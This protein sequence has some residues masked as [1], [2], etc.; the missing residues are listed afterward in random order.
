MGRAGPAA[1]DHR[2]AR[3]PE[4]RPVA[5]LLSVGLSRDVAVHVVGA[6]YAD[7]PGPLLTYDD[8]IERAEQHLAFLHRYRNGDDRL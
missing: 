7:H 4:H 8:L 5:W 3:R 1:L 6:V 2:H